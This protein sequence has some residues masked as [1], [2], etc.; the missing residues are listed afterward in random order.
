M[1]I[2]LNEVYSFKLV[3]SE[4]IVARVLEI[5]SD[6]LVVEEPVSITTNG[7]GIGLIP[8]LFTSEPQTKVR[9]NTN[10]IALTSVTADNIKMKYLEAT[11]G[12]KV[13]TKK[14]VLG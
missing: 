8:T 11:T 6:Y 7:Q 14:L 2:K 13:P 5:G 12:I 3:S 1:E 10:S 9:L 4:E